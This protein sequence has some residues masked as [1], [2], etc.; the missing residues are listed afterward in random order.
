[1]PLYI[2]NPGTQSIILDDLGRVEI[3]ASTIDR[4]LESE[5]K[6]DIL[7]RSGDLYSNILNGNL[8]AKN[9]D[10]YGLSASQLSNY[11]KTQVYVSI[12]KV[13]LSTLVSNNALSPSINYSISD[14][15]YGGTIIVKANSTNSLSQEATWIKNTDLRSFGWIRL[16][17]GSSGSVNS[18]TVNGVNQMSA[19]VSYATS[20]T[21]TV[22]NVVTNIN[23]NGSATYT[24]VAMM[25]AI[26]LVSKTAGTSFNGLAVSGTTTTLTLGG[27]QN[28]VRGYNPTQKVL[29]I[30]YDFNT[31]VVYSCYDPVYNNRIVN[32]LTYHNYSVASLS[33]NPILDFR[34]GD[35]A[36]LDNTIKKG[37][38]K[39]VYINGDAL[40]EANSF[41]DYAFIRNIIATSTS[42][43]GINSGYGSEAII[44]NN[45]LV[46][47][48]TQIIRNIANG[49][50][51]NN[52]L[53]G[54]QAKIS[55]NTIN[56]KSDTT[57]IISGIT[58]NILSG[59]LASINYNQL[60][61]VGNVSSA[62]ARIS[63]NTLSASST[64]ILSNVIT[65]EASS[66]DNNILSTS[67]AA[68]RSNSLVGG[69]STISTNTLSGGTQPVIRDNSLIGKSTQINSN[70]VSSNAGANTGIT[71]CIL[72]G[73]GS[74]INSNTV[75]NSGFIGRILLEAVSASIN[76]IT[77]PTINPRI[78][79][80]QWLANN[81]VFMR[82]VKT[83]LNGTTNNGLAGSDITLGFIPSTKMYP[84][85]ATIECSGLVGLGASLQIGTETDDTSNILPATAITSLDAVITTGTITRS[86]ST[87]TN[88]R[89]VATP[90]AANI[91]AGSIDIYVTYQISNF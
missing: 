11:N 46:G 21:N 2:S 78:E 74:T 8:T 79:N 16:T 26:V 91:T 40:F 24:A 87:I 76:G 5:F 61:S 47:T 43:I 36:F 34:W 4:N 39:D 32:S 88:R 51:T 33:S 60:S 72:K 20:L 18:I 58:G 19:T 89:L 48:F 45:I 1:M 7:K 62:H 68:I 70:T 69:L 85:S 65:G 10:N 35:P 30:L 38:I 17:A 42:Y 77:T 81:T 14:S 53:S 25:D 80:I 52:I 37:Y 59:T 86:K 49:P 50:I 23:A 57:Y 71:D 29:E 27:A 44:R 9:G 67:N 64:I 83:G 66:I 63:G 12:T 6:E 54:S 15:N 31:D 90:T 55:S 28:T 13:D 22:T 41:H 56:V 84:V 73:S 82:I 75:A 3:S